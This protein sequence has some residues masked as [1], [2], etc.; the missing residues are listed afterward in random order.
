MLLLKCRLLASSMF[1]KSART[2]AG[3]GVSRT[4]LQRPKHPRARGAASR[5]F[6]LLLGHLRTHGAQPRFFARHVGLHRGQLSIVAGRAIGGG[7][8]RGCFG[9]SLLGGDSS[10]G[11]GSGGG[12]LGGAR[13]VGGGAKPLRLCLRC[14][15]CSGNLALAALAGGF[16]L[17]RLRESSA[18]GAG[19]RAAQRAGV[20]LPL[21]AAALTETLFESKGPSE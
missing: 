20:E 21:D 14:G 19:W 5:G 10:L 12:V 6:A 13:G 17:L 9:G 2:A 7:L 11:L 15:C 18:V 8:R 4:A 3:K 16:R 1:S